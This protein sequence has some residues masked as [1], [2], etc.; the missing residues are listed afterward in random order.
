MESNYEIQ[1]EY[2]PGSKLGRQPTEDYGAE[3]YYAEKQALIYQQ[4]IR[5]KRL[6]LS[7]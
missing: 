2:L 6:S 4:H 7:I 3:A 5:S 1:W